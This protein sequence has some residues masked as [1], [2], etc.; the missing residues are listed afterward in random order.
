M[1]LESGDTR[2]LHT[3]IQQLYTLHDLDTFGM[4][5][6][7]IVDR[8]VPSD[9]IDF[10]LTNVRARQVS[11]IFL[12]EFRGYTPEMQRVI[13]HY[14]GE[15]P[16]AAR[17]PQTLH[18]VSKISDFITQKE[19]HGL[20]GL[21]QQYFRPLDIED[22]ITFFFPNASPDPGISLTQTNAILV[23][24]SLNRNRCNFTERDRSIL[25]L[26]RP[27]LAQAYTN[28][29]QYQQLQQDLLQI[30]QSLDRLVALFTSGDP[31]SAHPLFLELATL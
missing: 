26:L 27:H 6:L 22:Q 30:Q 8:L 21:Y 12:P 31:T 5:A 13:H 28:A 29:Q 3:E 1:E 15:H 18:G 11:S 25:N 14:F 20:E 19:L 23:G 4:D 10:H 7:S 16:I 2:Q 24:V 17:M 9:I